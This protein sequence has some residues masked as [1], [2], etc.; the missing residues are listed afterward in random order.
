M[1]EVGCYQL[2]EEGGEDVR[3]EDNGFG[4][5]GTHEIEGCG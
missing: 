2:G 4:Y 1:D 3:E 5:A